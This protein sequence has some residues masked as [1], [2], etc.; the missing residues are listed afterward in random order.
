MKVSQLIEELQKI[1]PETE[2]FVKGYEGGYDTIGK[3]S[4]VMDM[5]LDVNKEWYYGAH[6][7]AKKVEVEK[8]DRYRIV[9]GIIITKE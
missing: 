4:D 2:V 5:A 6:Q 1:D 8:V 7:K 9:K 3:I